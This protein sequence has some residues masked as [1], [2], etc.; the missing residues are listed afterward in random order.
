MKKLIILS[1]SV[2]FVMAVIQLPAQVVNK[3]AI[4][5]ETKE[6]KKEIKTVRKELRKL[7][8]TMVSDL[9]KKQFYADF[10]N[11]TNVQWTRS[12]YFDEAGFTKDGKIMRAFYDTNNTLVGT[13]TMRTFGDLSAKTQKEIMT[14]Y[15]DYAIGKVVFYDDNEANTT[16]MV[17]Y[18]A[19]FD[20]EDSY[21][22]ELSKD[23]KNVILKVNPA[24]GLMVFTQF[25]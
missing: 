2:F 5:T 12:N 3:D 19:Q 17:L 9:S 7:P 16:D 8:G 18:N 23:K 10:G 20:D 1:M 6:T 14:K 21:F 4:K 22:V 24:G 15:K 25:S 11:V 13:T